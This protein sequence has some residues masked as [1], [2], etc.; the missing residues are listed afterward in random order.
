MPRTFSA[1][2]LS[3]EAGVSQHRVEWLSDVGILR[4]EGPG[5]FVWADV[6][7]VKMASALLDAGLSEA[8]L[9]R[10]V[11]EGWLNM[12]FAGEYLPYE[13]GPR[14]ARTFGAFVAD[15]GAASG[16]LPA[17]FETMGQPPPDPDAPIHVDEEDML[18][19]F[20]DVW[21]AAPGDDTMIRAARLLADGVRI[22]TLGWV[23]LVDEQFGEPARERLASREIDRFPDEVRRKYTTAANLV[24]E[25][26]TWLS[27][28]Y[29]ERRSVEG[30]VE[31]FERFLAL[32]DLT[33]MP[34]PL[35]PPAVAFVDLSGFTELTEAR[36][37]RIAVRSV[38]A[39][40]EQAHAVAME[41]GGRL[42]KLLGDGALLRLPDAER[43][44]SAA[45][46]IVAAMDEEG[47]TRAHAGVHAGPVIERD[48]DLFGRTV[49]LASR[50]ADAASPGEVLTS[51]TVVEA[52][53]GGRFRFEP[54]AQTELKG[55]AEPT[56]LYRVLRDGSGGRG[57][58]G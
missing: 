19:R 33:P 56:A 2:E 31:G 18:R 46:G 37:D 58:S 6:F 38:V 24:P 26:F 20:L 49:N 21:G 17:V 42:V 45:L 16:R 41:H 25:L 32:K 30:I 22:A 12:E 47:T 3:D 39:L 11:A 29:L 55:I 10:S 5:S 43:G 7:R 8:M 52:L 14:S 35:A 48:L 13:P 50:I 34:E 4:P 1:Q 28:R 53:A 54:F 40:Q 15:S 51:E 9:S 23:E 27:A 36:G 57:R 44:L